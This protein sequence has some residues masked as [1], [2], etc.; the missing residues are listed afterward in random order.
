MLKVASGKQTLRRMQ[1]FE[2]FFQVQ[3][4]CDLAVAET[5]RKSNDKKNRL[6]CGFSKLSSETEDSPSVSCWH[7]GH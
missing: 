2:W 1:V 4:W 3:K 7:M 5:P 6:K